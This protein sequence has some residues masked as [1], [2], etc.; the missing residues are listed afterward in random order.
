MTYLAQQFFDKSSEREYI[1][2]VWGDV[3]EDKGTI[4]EF[5]EDIPKTDYNDCLPR[6]DYAKAV[7]H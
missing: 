1:A 3:V 4:D 2:L 7:I 6:C 5:I